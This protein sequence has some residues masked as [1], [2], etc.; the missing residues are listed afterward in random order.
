MRGFDAYI[1]SAAEKEVKFEKIMLQKKI[2]VALCRSLTAS[3]LP[4]V[5]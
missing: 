4:V 2:N 5:W 3:A 1:Q